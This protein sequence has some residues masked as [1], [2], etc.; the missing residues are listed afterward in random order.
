MRVQISGS[1]HDR[2]V[3]INGVTLGAQKSLKLR[4]HSPDGFNW[5]YGGSGPAQLAL[6][7]LL[8]LY[9]M[10]FA[11]RN[12]QDFKFAVIGRLPGDS[13]FEI[14]FD[15]TDSIEEIREKVIA[16]IQST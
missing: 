10:E 9:G 14:V 16:Q 8:E 7:I 13:D 3:K 5:G 6:A 12:Y 15:R 2:S 1:A 4:N 11:L